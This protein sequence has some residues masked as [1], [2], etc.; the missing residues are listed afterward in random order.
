MKLE[1]DIDRLL[2]SAERQDTIDHGLNSAMTAWHLVDWVW[3]EIESTPARLAELGVQTKKTFTHHVLNACPELRYCQ[4]I[5]T[6]AK[7]LACE[8]KSHDPEFETGT[9]PRSRG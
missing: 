3:A 4:I 6:S 9:A 1:R 2:R 8:V 7:H 5:A